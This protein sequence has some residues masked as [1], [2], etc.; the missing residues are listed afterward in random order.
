M[1]NKVN[2]M[3]VGLKLLSV[4]IFSLRTSYNY[5]VRKYAEIENCF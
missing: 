1:V 3:S 5:S 4:I 2:K